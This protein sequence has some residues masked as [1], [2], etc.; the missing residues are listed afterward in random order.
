MDLTEEKSRLTSQFNEELLELNIAI[1]PARGNS[2]RIPGKNIRVFCGKPIIAYSIEAALASR[3]IDDVW[4]STDDPMIR[5]VAAQYGAKTPFERPL[6]IA[7]DYTVL[8]DVMIHAIDYAKAT[9]I[10]LDYACMIFATAPFISADD[11]DR[12]KSM[13]VTAKADQALS[14]SEFCSAPQ[15]AQYID[16]CGHLRYGYPEFC[17]VRSQDLKTMYHDAAQFVWG[18]ACSFYTPVTDLNI[19]PVIIDA[20]KVVDID[21]VED[22]N[23]AEYLFNAHRATNTE[24]TSQNI[25]TSE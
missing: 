23:Y 13:L 10:E 12:G 2:K 16:D 1:I 17:N 22:W 19:A 6:T 20:E 4:V 5:E 9:D 7:D 24:L 3:T 14:V 11:I 21:T 8:R 18:K 15:R 25:I